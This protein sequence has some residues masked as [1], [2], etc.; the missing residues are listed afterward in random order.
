M[1]FEFT[2][3]E[4]DKPAAD[5]PLIASDED[6]IVVEAEAV[7]DFD[8]VA[9]TS[10]SSTSLTG[11][12]PSQFPGPSGET[13]V[14]QLSRLHA[15]SLIFDLL[16]HG[17]TYL[18]P[19]A[20]GLLGAAQGDLT[21]LII[22]AMIF[23]PAFL[24]SVFRY[25][26]FRY[27]IQSDK[28]IVTSGLIFRN[29]RTVPVT[30]IQNIDFVQNPLHR[31][32]NVAEVKIETASGNKPEAT[33]RVL[34]MDK[35][36]ELRKAVFELQSKHSASPA[37]T[38]EGEN[39]NSTGLA[40][41]GYDL[42]ADDAAAEENETTTLLQVPTVWLIKAGLASN[43]GLIMVGVLI[44]AYFQFD[45]SSHFDIGWIQAMLPQNVS[46]WTIVAATIGGLILALILLRLLGIGWF[47]LRFH[48]YKLIGRGDDLRISCGLFT[49]VSATVPRG[50]IQ[51]ISI[52]RS[53]IMRM[54]GMASIR[55]ETAGGAGNSN[56]NA[57]ESV[58]KRWFVPA[59]P[60][61]Q[62][63]G[64]ISVLRPGLIWDESK[65]DFKSLSS[66]AGRRLSR[67]AAVH[68]ILIGLVG[69]AVTRPWG[70]VAGIVFLPLLLMWA[71]KKAKA[72]R[73]AR[74][75]N[76]VVYRSGVL[77][78]KISVTFF[79]KIQ[80]LSLEQSPF[81]RRWKMA[82]LSVDTAA[83]GPAEHR[84]QVPYLDA[85]FAEQELQLL[86]MKTGQQQ[87]VFG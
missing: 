34:S 70:W 77:N 68:S 46:T 30:R 59:I 4:S 2:N 39:A 50:R 25:F 84:I 71:A 24:V 44:G 86:R 87:P 37:L 12:L 49:R 81:D 33:L 82:S 1:S 31:I 58:S 41:A 85:S 32:M 51:F 76:G 26:T 73:Y 9:A 13:P 6:Q 36:E 48:G 16:A 55:I 74:T 45:R 60:E 61:H 7:P 69:L 22:S 72:M 20:F 66:R 10:Q 17:R 42:R 35:M 21:L 27:I 79:E 5:Q 15:T 11:S 63:A 56:E 19:A 57:S 53:L 47:I 64:L 83:A 67:L 23:V 14:N 40:E 18:V 54:L 78:R 29:V 75:E 43:R 28:L 65:L 80:T 62:V 52:H 8:M 38:V 3:P